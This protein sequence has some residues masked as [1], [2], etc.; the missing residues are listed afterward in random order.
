MSRLLSIAALVLLAGCF[1]QA[2]PSA[3]SVPEAESTPPVFPEVDDSRKPARTPTL[4]PS[5]AAVRE[6]SNSSVDTL[7]PKLPTDPARLL[8]L[9]VSHGS[10]ILRPH[11]GGSYVLQKQGGAITA[12]PLEAGS[13]LRIGFLPP[14]S[15]HTLVIRNGTEQ[16]RAEF[17][18]LPSPWAWANID[19]ATVRPG[20]ALHARNLCTAGFMLRD[21]T[22]E[23]LYLLTA[24]HCFAAGEEVRLDGEIPVG[25][26]VVST[27]DGLLDYALV[28]IHDH[29][30][31]LA[32][33][34]SLTWDGF[35]DPP[36]D[37]QANSQD[38][39]CFHGHAVALGSHESLRGR[40]GRYWD[41]ATETHGGRRIEIYRGSLP[42]YKGDSGAGL[43]HHETGAPIGLL[44]SGIAGDMAGGMTFCSVLSELQQIHG[45]DTAG[46]F[47]NYTPTPITIAPPASPPTHGDASMLSLACE[48]TR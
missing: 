31:H 2:N 18:T 24:G 16:F 11:I 48:T 40:C 12:G 23:S 17:T 9:D 22:N 35:A 7:E 6:E 15:T 8:G 38:I 13:E 29:M 32:H 19:A 10:V 47:Q 1:G 3:P 41:V 4:T 34:S 44:S 27:Y 21:A 20:M 42:V 14:N 26:V 43:L 30:R 45:L 36:N 28:R 46:L 39:A 37:A 5:P 25:D 33:P